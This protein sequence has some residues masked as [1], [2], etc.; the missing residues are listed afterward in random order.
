[1]EVLFGCDMFGGYYQGIDIGIWIIDIKMVIVI[2]K[3]FFNCFVYY[4]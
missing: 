4:E 3:Y 2:S 1:M